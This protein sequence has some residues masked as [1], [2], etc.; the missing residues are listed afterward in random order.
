MTISTSAN[1][2]NEL[3]IKEIHVKNS[4]NK[5]TA[6]YFSVEVDDTEY[7][8]WFE[9]EHV[10]SKYLSTDRCDAAVVCLLYY[11]MRFNYNIR[12]NCS[13]SETLYYNLQYQLIPQLH[14]ADKNLHRIMIYPDRLVK[15]YSGCQRAIGMGM[16][17]GVD[18]FAT[19]YEY[20]Y[21][22]L[23]KLKNYNITHFTYHQVGAHHGLSRG[24]QGPYTSQEL[25]EQDLKKV[26]TFCKQ[27]SYPLIVI[28]SNLDDL[29]KEA[30]PFL[31]FWE[32]YSFRNAGAVLLLQKLFSKFYVS[33]GFNL[34]EF[35]CGTIWDCG[36]YDPVTLPLLSTE[37]T[38]FYRSNQNWNRLKKI[39]LLSEFSPSYDYLTVCMTHSKNCGNCEK[40]R[41]TLLAMDVLGVL[42]RYANSFDI[43]SYRNE[44]R[45]QWLE[46][47]WIEAPKLTFMREILEYA[48]END[49][50]D[51]PAPKLESI[52]EKKIF[53][54]AKGVRIRKFPHLKAKILRENLLERVQILGKFSN[55]YY[56]EMLTGEKGYC[57]ADYVQKLTE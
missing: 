6:I 5:K 18:S 45:E 22:E 49:F 20:N 56:I 30:F 33:S 27:Y 14:A 39:Q 1:E 44:Y 8:L 57:K 48:L 47:L 21:T 17:L 23:K 15:K 29:L 10:W 24:K 36:R 51:L 31:Y 54:M 7:S 12:L 34:N 11:A 3:C 53:G 2:Q 38:R 52:G 46:E 43:S 41:P 16:S 55:W 28:S 32:S 42:D 50:S 19:L 37:N 9:I 13:M 40:C 4:D 35:H 26:Q 25:F